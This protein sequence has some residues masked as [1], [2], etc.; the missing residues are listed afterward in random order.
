MKLDI[1]MYLVTDSTYHSEESL[2]KTVDEA[3]RGG[4][5]IVQLREKNLTSREY[6]ERAIKVKK[7]TD[8]YDI[9]LI[10]DDRVDIVMA[11]GAAGVHVGD[12]DMPVDYARRILGK[13]KIV[14]A[15]AKTVEKAL[16]VYEKGA[17]YLGVGAI[18]PTTT[19]VL[20]KLTEVSTL[21]DIC[22][23]VPIP[24]LAIGGLNS[25]NIDVL[26]DSPIDGVAVVSAIMKSKDPMKAASE[27]KERIDMIIKRNRK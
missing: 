21:N 18:F 6:L 20:T 1:S 10:I 4:V 2:L 14:G 15:T 9:P 23:A 7:V 17:D 26:N 24:V 25:G 3:C 27:L 13:D 12:K 22:R 5:T 19:K 16:E 8:K 11:S